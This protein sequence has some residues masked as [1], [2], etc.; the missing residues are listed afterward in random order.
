MDIPDKPVAVTVCLAGLA[1][2]S[3]RP[4]LPGHTFL[5]R[6]LDK[7]LSFAIPLSKDLPEL[8]LYSSW[9]S[10]KHFIRDALIDNQGGRTQTWS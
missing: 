5:R 2:Y 3:L 6:N 4:F 10:F 1:G 8:W 9:E 7:Y